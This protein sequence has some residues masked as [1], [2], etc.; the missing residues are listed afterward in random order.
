LGKV[1]GGVKNQHLGTAGSTVSNDCAQKSIVAGKYSLSKLQHRKKKSGKGPV[2]SGE[3]RSERVAEGG[4][5]QPKR[6]KKNVTGY[7]L[8]KSKSNDRGKVLEPLKKRKACGLG[9]GGKDV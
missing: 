5:S 2:E 3:K 6:G 8:A 1:F 4:K 7:R 9:G